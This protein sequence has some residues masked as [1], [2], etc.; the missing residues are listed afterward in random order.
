[1]STWLALV[2]L[3]VPIYAQ[4]VVIDPIDWVP[5]SVFSGVTS[6][7]IDGLCTNTTYTIS[8]LNGDGFYP[9]SSTIPGVSMPISATSLASVYNI[10]FSNP[11][12]NLG[13]YITDL[14]VGESIQFVAPG[15]FPVSATPP[16]ALDPMTNTVTVGTI[17]QNGWINWNGAVSEIRFILRRSGNSKVGIKEIR[18]DGCGNTAAVEPVNAFDYEVIQTNW[19][20]LEVAKFCSTSALVD[21]SA[22]QNECGYFIGVAPVTNNNPLTVGPAVYSGWPTA[23]GQAPGSIDLLNNAL[24]SPA[25]LLAGQIYRL[26]LATGPCWETEQ[27]YFKLET[28][29]CLDDL[30][31][32]YDC[33]NQVVSV[34]TLPND[35]TVVSANW[36]YNDG[37]GG[38]PLLLSWFGDVSTSKPVTAT[39]YYTVELK[40]T[41]P[42]GVECTFS[43]T[44]FIDIEALEATCCMVLGS[45]PDADWGNSFIP[46]TTSCGTLP[47]YCDEVR[48]QLSSSGCEDEYYY[49]IQNYLV[50]PICTPGNYLGASGV[51]SGPLGGPITVDV[52]ALSNNQLQVGNFYMFSFGLSTN[53]GFNDPNNIENW[54]Y[55][56]FRYSNDCTKSNRIE[57]TNENPATVAFDSKVYPNPARETITLETSES[58]PQTISII[59]IDGKQVRQVSASSNTRNVYDISDLTPGLYFIT[60]EM[61]NGRMEQHRFIVE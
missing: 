22:S 40:Y 23:T 36:E 35:V 13:I 45:M 60:V 19:G 52:V 29:E 8:S 32:E 28:C 61:E 48:V 51:I 14:D 10:V 42:N 31:L 16:F 18:Y 11:V 59:S 24:A 47:V 37:S 12:N 7:P 53:G 4:Q 41:L 9:P 17:N 3:L 46:W 15:F 26:T 30:E 39:G 54:H 38:P 34:N 2:G 57:V 25:N 50:N 1:M 44:I 33:F 58:V 5:G 43:Q 20:P 49:G 55:H 6:P 21:G 27:L 56:I